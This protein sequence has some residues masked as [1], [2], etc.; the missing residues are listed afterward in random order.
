VTGRKAR[1]YGREDA[2]RMAHDLTVTTPTPTEP[3]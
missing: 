3:P 2:L 1:Y